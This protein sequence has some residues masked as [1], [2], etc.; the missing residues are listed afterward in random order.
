MTFSNE[1][2]QEILPQLTELLDSS[3]TISFE[4]LNPDPHYGTYAGTL[5][6]VKGTEY[7]YRSLRA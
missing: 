3:K 4:V 1:T 5:I 2:L 7:R 6:E